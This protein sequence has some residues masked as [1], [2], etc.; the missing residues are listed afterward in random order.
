[1]RLLAQ[2]LTALQ[3]FLKLAGR[4][5]DEVFVIAVALVKFKRV[6]GHPLVRRIGVRG[7]LVHCVLFAARAFSLHAAQLVLVDDSFFHVISLSAAPIAA[8]LRNLLYGPRAHAQRRC[9]SLIPFAR[10]KAFL[11]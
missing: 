5:T 11:L 1:M 10:P 2:T 4:E 9:S 8:Q 7:E 3:L 6:I